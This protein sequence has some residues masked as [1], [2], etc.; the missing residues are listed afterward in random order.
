MCTATAHRGM[1]SRYATVAETGECEEQ[2]GAHWTALGHSFLRALGLE[3]VEMENSE[4]F[5]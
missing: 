2:V 4:F 3:H 5:L 1:R